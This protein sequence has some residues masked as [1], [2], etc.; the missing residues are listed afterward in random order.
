VRFI[1]GIKR[2]D[3]IVN[4]GRSP[5]LDINITDEAFLPTAEELKPLESG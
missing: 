1:H 2:G 4:E 3:S 5:M